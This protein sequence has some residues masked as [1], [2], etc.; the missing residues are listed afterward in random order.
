LGTAV[1]FAGAGLS[2]P[3]KAAK[4]KDKTTAILAV[5]KIIQPTNLLKMQ[6]CHPNLRNTRAIPPTRRG[7]GSVH[8]RTSGQGPLTKGFP[9]LTVLFN[10]HIPNRL[11]DC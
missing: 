5:V 1:F 7:V 8:L 6:G 2:Q 4:P 11:K 3:L 10:A 9:F